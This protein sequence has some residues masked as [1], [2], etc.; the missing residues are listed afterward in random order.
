MRI[1]LSLLK[2]LF[3]GF[4]LIISSNAFGSEFVWCDNGDQYQCCS[5]EAYWPISPLWYNSG[6][7]RTCGDIKANPTNTCTAKS[8]IF[9]TKNKE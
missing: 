5:N 1:N 6:S 8:G 2:G 7:D 4:V 3:A 9:N